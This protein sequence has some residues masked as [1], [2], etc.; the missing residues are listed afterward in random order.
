[1]PATRD[2]IMLPMQHADLLL[3]NGNLITLDD[4]RP[5]ATAVAV[6]N[7]KILAL[8]S[9]RELE[10]LTIP[11]TQRI[12]LEN[13]TL[14]PGF[15]DSHIHLYW[16]GSQLLRQADLVGATSIDEILNRLSQLKSNRPTGWLQGHGFDH[17][18]LREKQFPTRADLDRISKTQPIIISRICGHA[19]VANSPALALLSP[20]ERSKGDQH[21]GLY[22]ETAAWA[23][24]K[25]IPDLSE[26]EAQQAILAAAKIALQTGITTVQTMLDTPNQMIG[27]SRLH[28]QNRLP[29][30]VVAMPP[31]SAIDD[32]H[33]YGLRSRFGDD[34]L[35]FGAC[36]LFSDGSL[37]AQTALLSDPYADKPTTRG[38]RFYDPA[39]LKQKC[40]IAEQNGFQLAIHAIGDQ[41][42]R[43][44]I[45]AIE[46]ALEG[47]SNQL[48][49]HR[50]E[51]ASL[52]PPDC[53]ERLAKIQTVVTIQP[54]FVTSDTWTLNRLGPTRTPHAYP[55]KSMLSAGIPIALS[56]DC[57]VEK[58]DAFDTLAAAVGRHDWSP[59]ETLTPLEALRAY[60][61]G[62]AHAAFLEKSLGSLQVGKLA[63]FVILSADPTNLSA[64][65]LRNLKAEKV[66]IAGQCVSEMTQ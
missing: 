13:K 6:S 31:F 29:L 40:R 35:Q 59:H 42:L 55:F 20:D 44:T 4:S 25:L 11:Q 49:R 36:K 56:S 53:L 14:T 58:L 2:K 18:K 28:R 7:G 26:E 41:A 12:N 22:T 21:S 32:L 1:M 9:D 39:D 8:G 38:L 16:F 24:Y 17:D 45:D 15:I 10:K 3:T 54:Q 48:H 46:Y 63:D 51:H 66:F 43:E 5:R 64:P 50:V 34:R 57:P 61:L 30:R 47:A 62:S 27:Y 60:T 33:K 52:C 37:G 23:F 65:Q 19:T